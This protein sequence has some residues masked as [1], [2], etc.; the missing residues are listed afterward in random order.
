MFYLFTKNI[1][2]K[3]SNCDIISLQLVTISKTLPPN[4]GV[5]GSFY[6]LGCIYV[7]LLIS[8][9]VFHTAIFINSVSFSFA[10]SSCSFYQAFLNEFCCS[11]P[12]LIAKVKLSQFLSCYYFE[13]DLSVTTSFPD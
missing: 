2:F 9:N 1:P 3:E 7:L 6:Q 5:F 11:F 10:F 13:V 12:E 8:V 4:F